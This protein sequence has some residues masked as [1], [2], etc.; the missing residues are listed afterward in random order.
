MKRTLCVL[1]TGSIL[2]GL[3]GCSISNAKDTDTY[4]IQLEMIT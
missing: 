3:T 2:L 1:L 4:E